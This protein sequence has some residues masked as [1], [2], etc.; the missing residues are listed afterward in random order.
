VVTLLRDDRVA[1]EDGTFSYAVQADNGI[2]TAVEGVV[3]S[4]GQINQQ[5]SYT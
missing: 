2:N 5:G 1:N 3:G 4:A